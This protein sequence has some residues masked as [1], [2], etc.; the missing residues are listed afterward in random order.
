MIDTEPR[1]YRWTREEYYR[2]CEEGWFQDKRV[3]LIGGEIVE[4]SAQKNEHAISIKLAEDALEAI[5]GVNFWVRTQMS[6]DLSPHSV[7]DP[8]LAVIPGNFRSYVG[9][10]IP[11]SALLVVEVSETT[12]YYDRN[13]KASL[14]AASGIADYWIINVVQRQVEVYRDPVPDA[15]QAFGYRYASRT[16]LDP[17]EVVSPLALPGA[18]VAVADLL[19]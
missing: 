7:P 4:M 19:P 2:L 17:G 13:Q 11:T 1:P 10:G 5:F 18:T 12:L 8:D 16:I 15:T 3:Q 6:L 9:Q 14:Y